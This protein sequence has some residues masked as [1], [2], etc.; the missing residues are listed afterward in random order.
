MKSE[1]GKKTRPFLYHR[2]DEDILRYMKKPVREK[3]QWLES[4]MEFF[5][6]AMPEKVKELRD[7]LRRGEL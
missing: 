3:L 5:H 1:T 6:E 2:T 4:Q 7:R